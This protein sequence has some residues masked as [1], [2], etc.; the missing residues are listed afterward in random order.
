MI[1]CET[2]NANREVAK[3]REESREGRQNMNFSSRR[4][5][6]PLRAFA[7]V[8]ILSC[9]AAA[10]GEPSMRR[11]ETAHYNIHTDV[12]DALARDLCRRMDT[13]YEEYA[14]RL[15]EFSPP[16][17][18]PKFEVYIFAKRDDYMNFTGNRMPN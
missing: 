8:L 18:G 17:G 14:K 6:A 10:R 2:E 11:Y 3:K 4:Y 5:F 1:L 13:M 7:V 9:A 12:D 16:S 15:V